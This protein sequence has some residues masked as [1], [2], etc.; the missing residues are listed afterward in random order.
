MSP[1]PLPPPPPSA[2]CWGRLSVMTRCNCFQREIG[3]MDTLWVATLT[4]TAPKIA[5]VRKERRGK[6]YQRQRCEFHSRWTGIF[7][8]LIII[9]E[10]DRNLVL[11]T[12]VVNRWITTCWHCLILALITMVAISNYC[13]LNVTVFW[14]TLCYS[15][16]RGCNH[17]RF[18]LNAHSSGHE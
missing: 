7:L 5:T 12:V 6:T 15:R 10:S 17:G 8:F 11:M 18:K 1:A 14:C 3:F 9:L 16:K 4:S 13:D 2:N